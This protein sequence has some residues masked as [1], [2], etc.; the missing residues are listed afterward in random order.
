MVILNAYCFNTRKQQQLNMNH[1][2]KRDWDINDAVVPQVNES[3][4]D[5]FNEWTDGHVRLIYPLHNE[6]AKKHI[7]GWAM[8]NTN[9]HNVNI[10]KKSCLGVLVCSQNCT[11]SNGNRINLRP[12]ICDKARRKQEG[13]ACPNKTCRGGRLEIKPCRGHCGYP[14]TH[15]WR[16]SNNAI[17]FQAKGVHD[18]PKPE[19]KN[20]SVSKRAFGRVSLV[21]RNSSAATSRGTGKKSSLT[22][23]LSTSLRQMKSHSSF[24]NKVLKRSTKTTNA[25]THT[26]A[27]EIYQFNNC[28]KCT[29]RSQCTCVIEPLNNTSNLNYTNP[30]HHYESLTASVPHQNYTHTHNIYQSSNDNSNTKCEPTALLT[31]NH[32]HITYN[33]PIYHHTS[34]GVLNNPTAA[35]ASSPKTAADQPLH[36]CNT[37]PSSAVNGVSHYANETLESAKMSYHHYHTSAASGYGSESSLCYNNNCDGIS[38]FNTNL[39]TNY[40]YDLHPPPPAATAAVS[41]S[42]RHLSTHNSSLELQAQELKQPYPSHTTETSEFINYA[43]LK[44]SPRQ[45]ASAAA[46]P[47][48]LNNEPEFINYSELK[49]YPHIM[50][51]SQATV[52]TK[53]SKLNTNE[54]P[55]HLYQH[56]NNR[57]AENTSH[58]YDNCYYS[59]ATR[60]KQEKTKEKY[61]M[62]ST[63]HNPTTANSYDYD[64]NPST[65]NY[66]PLTSGHHG[67][68]TSYPT[69]NNYYDTGPSNATQAH[70]TA[71]YD[72]NGSPSSSYASS[73]GYDQM[74]TR[75][76]SLMAGPP[77]H[78]YAH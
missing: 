20:S 3:D 64:Y 46:V 44:Y 43:D 16:H 34:A 78:T 55:S 52:E 66:F 57:S 30:L 21:S 62:D 75:G 67:N 29:T 63:S 70:S 2:S 37:S 74:N 19:P 6:E 56:S 47:E 77:C 17:F 26:A 40:D 25:M 61:L 27:L 18:H 35:I 71:L 48:V 13:K 69:L 72:Y 49:H 58:S 12:A 39:T 45:P 24:L 36:S 41:L 38:N 59:S 11:L 14:V 7:S 8:R 54:A 65:N 23:N 1:R 60:T 10:L 42:S 76:T 5:E 4:F 15:F 73:Y 50:E 51:S 9:N 68:S 28:N 32:Q 33:Y 22:N 53:P 31:V